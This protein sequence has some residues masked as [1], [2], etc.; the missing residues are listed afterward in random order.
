[1]AVI[2][3]TVTLYFTELGRLEK[4]T[5]DLNLHLKTH[6]L[7]RVKNHSYLRKVTQ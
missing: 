5:K 7:S 1:M 4:Q 6:S 2:D 3:E